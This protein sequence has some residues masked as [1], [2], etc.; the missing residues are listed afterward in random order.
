MTTQEPSPINNAQL[1]AVVPD[2]GIPATLDQSGQHRVLVGPIL[3][4]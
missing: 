2:H 3:N 1:L 4:I